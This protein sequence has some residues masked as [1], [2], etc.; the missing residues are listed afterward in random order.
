MSDTSIMMSS[1]LEGLI[2]DLEGS[3]QYNN[4]VICALKIDEKE[5]KC[6]LCEISNASIEFE[7]IIEIGLEIFK[8]KA[9]IIIENIRLFYFNTFVSSLDGPF[10]VKNIKLKIDQQSKKC[11]L[12]IELKRHT[13]K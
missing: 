10:K 12:F 3:F 13:N 8:N 1:E 7:T 11:K 5:I 2:P 4:D 6:L 9:N